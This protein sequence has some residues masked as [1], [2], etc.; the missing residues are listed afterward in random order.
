MSFSNSVVVLLQDNQWRSPSVIHSLNGITNGSRYAEH[1]A[2]QQSRQSTGP[3]ESA[4]FPSELARTPQPSSST[5]TR[6]E[7]REYTRRSLDPSLLSAPV[8]RR[9]RGYVAPRY[10]S[11]SGAVYLERAAVKIPNAGE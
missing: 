10:I 9:D 11:D 7:H 6:A 1:I 8:K 4:E 5:L 2:H 3:A